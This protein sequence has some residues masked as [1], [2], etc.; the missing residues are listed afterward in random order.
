VLA[1]VEEWA[2][3]RGEQ[4]AKQVAVNMNVNDGLEYYM[5]QRNA[6]VKCNRMTL[7]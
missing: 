7:N 1:L 5:K 2:M 4:K 6:I 3:M